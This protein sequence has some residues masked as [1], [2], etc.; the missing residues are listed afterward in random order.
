M[1]STAGLGPVAAIGVGV[2]L[3]V[4]VTLLPALLVI[5]GRWMFWPKRPTFGSPSRRQTGLWARVGRRIAVRPRKVWV[6]HRRPAGRRLP[7]PVPARHQRAVHRR[8]ATP[9]SSTRSSA[10]RC[11]P[12]TAW[13][14]RPTPSWWW[15]TPTAADDGAPRRWPAID[16]RRA[17]RPSPSV[18]GGVAFIQAAAEPATSA[19]PG[20]FDTRRGRCATAVH[21]VD[22]ADA[23]VGGCV[24]D[25][26]RHQGRLAPRQPGDHPDRPARGAADPDAAAAGR[27]SRR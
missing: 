24:G 3:L 27:S 1:N 16:G 5:C 26:P 9:R 7:R 2:T 21:A 13:S 11:S 10:R 19:S 6:G 12:T 18:K 23:L 25:L 22:G 15:P 8:T 20:A 14:T 4:M 17:S